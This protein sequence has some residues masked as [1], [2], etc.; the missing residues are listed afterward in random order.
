[1]CIVKVEST[2]YVDTEPTASTKAAFLQYYTSEKCTIPPQSG[3]I[4]EAFGTA[5]DKNAYINR[6][7]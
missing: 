4:L 6:D 3:R 1:M 5:Q 2:L 7:M